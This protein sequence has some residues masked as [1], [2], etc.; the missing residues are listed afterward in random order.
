MIKRYRHFLIFN[1][2][3]DGK[4]NVKCKIVTVPVKLYHLAY[5]EGNALL[6]R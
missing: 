2:K 1:G 6:K 3:S 5:G 4:T